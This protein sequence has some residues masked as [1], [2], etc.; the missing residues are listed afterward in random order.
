[1][2]LVFKTSV[3]GDS[4]IDVLAPSLNV[5]LYNRGKWNF[6]LEDCDKILRIEGH[7]LQCEEI[8]IL[9]SRLGY[10]CMELEDVVEP[11]AVYPAAAH[12]L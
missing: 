4:D 10:F 5:L 2:V 6:D 8:T 11:K 1:M 12:K 7:A 9:L 3:Q